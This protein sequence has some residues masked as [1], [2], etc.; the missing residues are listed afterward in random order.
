MSVWLRSWVYTKTIMESVLY[1]GDDNLNNSCQK[2]KDSFWNAH[3]R[4]V[5][6][7]ELGTAIGNV[8][9]HEVGHLYGDISHDPVGT[10]Y[11]M[12]EKIDATITPLFWSESSKQFWQTRFAKN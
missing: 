10:C 3:Q 7:K 1:T 2:K 5:T 12:T 8:A 6:E 11:L 9:S 4:V